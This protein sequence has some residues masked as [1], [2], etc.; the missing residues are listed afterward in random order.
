M[1]L[2][3]YTTVYKK[4]QSAVVITL[5]IVIHALPLSNLNCITRT[6]ELGLK[7]Y[8]AKNLQ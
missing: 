5:L 7:I 4:N 2:E 1:A 8:N 3:G 6:R